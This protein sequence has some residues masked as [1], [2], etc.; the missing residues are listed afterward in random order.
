MQHVVAHARSSVNNQNVMEPIAQLQNATQLVLRF[1]HLQI[2]RHKTA[3]LLTALD[4]F[5]THHHA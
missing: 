2:A 3:L 5:A 4:L 1:H